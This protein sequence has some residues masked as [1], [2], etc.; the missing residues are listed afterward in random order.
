MHLTL[1]SGLLFAL[2]VGAWGGINPSADPASAASFSVAAQATST[3]A[4]TVT[5]TA[6]GVSQPL[7]TTNTTPTVAATVTATQT[8]TDTAGTVVTPTATIVQNTPIPLPTAG[9]VSQLRLNPF[10]WTFLTSAPSPNMGPFAWASLALMIALLGVSGY[11]YFYKRPQWKRANPVPYRAANRW[12]P[13]GLWVG[14]I[15]LFILLFRVV[16]LDFF[17]LRLWLYLWGLAA[18]V[19]AGLFFYWYRTALPLERAKYEKTQRARQYTPGAA[20][21]VRGGASRPVAGGAKTQARS[22]AQPKPTTTTPASGAAIP[23]PAQKGES[24][25]TKSKRTGKQR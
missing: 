6:T 19:A 12:A 21:P 24:A 14:V 3:I 9:A 8:T 10:D 15:G 5:A 1:L 7:T 2:A 18:L 22:K 23:R 20:A 4:G 16:S 11:F 25:S 13:V 17:N